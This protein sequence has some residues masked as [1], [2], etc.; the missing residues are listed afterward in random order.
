MI[1]LQIQLILSKS[2]FFLFT[3]KGPTFFR[4]HL[5]NLKMDNGISKY[6]NFINSRI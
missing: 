5:L 6:I 2:N 3:N 4:L 1:E